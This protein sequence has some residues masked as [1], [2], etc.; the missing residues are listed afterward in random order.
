M[1]WDQIAGR[2]TQIK[3][4]IREKW[5]RFTDDDLE[6]IAGSKDKFVGRFQ[7]LYGIAKEE[8]EREVDDW[9]K[10][11]RPDASRTRRTAA[12]AAQE[13]TKPS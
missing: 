6:V 9:L 3:G 1:N 10:E 8:A 2:W 11:D 4:E 13:H 12:K 5:G 7:V